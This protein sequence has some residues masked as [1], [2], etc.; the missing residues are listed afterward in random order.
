MTITSTDREH[1]RR[2]D[3]D[4]AAVENVG[5]RAARLMGSQLRLAAI[6]ALERGDD[7]RPTVQRLV[8]LAAPTL[9]D[10]M[11]AGHLRGR[12]RQLLTAAPMFRVKS[13]VKLSGTAYDGTIDFLKKRL[14]VTAEQVAALA[15]IYTPAAVKVLSLTAD[16]AAKTVAKAIS[17]ITAANLHVREGVSVLRQAFNAAGITPTS[18]FQLEA[19]FRTQTQIAYSAGRWNGLQDPEVQSI[20][21]AFKYVTVGDDRVRPTHAAME[22]ITLPKDNAFWKTNWPPNGYSCRCA[23]LEIYRE[24]KIVEPVPREVDGMVIQPVADAGFGF[25][26][27]EVYRDLIPAA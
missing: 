16:A 22:G 1:A 11:V 8:K 15:E 20:L 3:A 2:M 6:A 27:G 14:D 7:P 24:M 13:K 26:A 23:A 21:K 5:I 12:L 17:D 4:R 9:T 10:A 25:N 18:S 19:V